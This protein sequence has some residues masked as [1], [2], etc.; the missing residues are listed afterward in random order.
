[1]GPGLI[2][3]AQLEEQTLSN[4][5]A[6]RRKPQYLQRNPQGIWHILRK[7]G[8]LPKRRVGDNTLIEINGKTT[9]LRQWVHDRAVRHLAAQSDAA[10]R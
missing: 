7:H 4:L 2:A 10:A 8:V 3:R 9:L 1:M 6:V 5:E